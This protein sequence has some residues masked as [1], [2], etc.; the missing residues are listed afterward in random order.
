[1]KASIKRLN[2]LLCVHLCWMQHHEILLQSHHVDN[3]VICASVNWRVAQLVLQK[4]NK[5]QVR[6]SGGFYYSHRRLV[7][8]GHIG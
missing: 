3:A 7:Q 4:M 8:M 6:M 2:K 1:M 5:A